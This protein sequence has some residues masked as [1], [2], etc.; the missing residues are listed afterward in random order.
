MPDSNEQA[1]VVCEGPAT[2]GSI[3]AICNH[4][5]EALQTAPV[6]E[7]DCGALT[8]VDVCFLQALIS[9]RLVAQRH[10]IELRMQQPIAQTLC[11]ALE[12]G[13]FIAKSGPPRPD[14]EFWTG[15]V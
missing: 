10:G 3:E 5:H 4:L 1:K 8:E 13:G 14:Q 12:R 9:A 2:I 11:D 7:V 6:V 15:K